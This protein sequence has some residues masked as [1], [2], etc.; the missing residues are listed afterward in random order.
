MEQKVNAE[1]KEMLVKVLIMFSTESLGPV[2]LEVN[3]VKPVNLELL[4]LL[5]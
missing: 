5:D 3:L 2:V 1:N 4:D